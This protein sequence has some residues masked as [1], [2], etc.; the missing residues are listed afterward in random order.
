MNVSLTRRR[1]KKEKKKVSWIGV[2]T[3]WEIIMDFQSD[4]FIQGKIDRCVPL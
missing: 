2:V 3:L 4:S 1:K